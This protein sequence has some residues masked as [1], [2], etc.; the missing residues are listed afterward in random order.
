MVGD[1][2]ASSGRGS[3]AER[4]IETRQCASAVLVRACDQPLL[5]I[6]NGCG[7]LL[8]L[9]LDAVVCRHL[10]ATTPPRGHALL[11]HDARF[12]LSEEDMAA[13]TAY[14]DGTEEP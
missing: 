4:P 5:T 14:E 10:A 11:A 6:V 8:G 13:L 1:A 3:A 7:L 2:R 12:S 9:Q